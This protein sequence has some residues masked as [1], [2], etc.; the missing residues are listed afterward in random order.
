MITKSLK[1]PFAGV[2]RNRKSKRYRQYNGQ[3]K[4]HKQREREKKKHYSEKTKIEQHEP[5]GAIYRYY[6]FFGYI[7]TIKLVVI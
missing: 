1:I 2:I 6:Y 5:V 4:N 7:V 3:K